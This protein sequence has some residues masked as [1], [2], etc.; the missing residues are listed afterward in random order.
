MPSLPYF[1]GICAT[2][3]IVAEYSRGTY[4]KAESPVWCAV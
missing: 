1:G 2:C 4:T 3:I